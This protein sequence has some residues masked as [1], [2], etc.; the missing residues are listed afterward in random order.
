MAHGVAVRRAI[1][2]A[3]AEADKQAERGSYHAI[4]KGSKPWV[5][6]GTTGGRT[7]YTLS[8]HHY[9]TEML[10]WEYHPGHG[11]YN[12]IGTWTGWGSVSDQ[13]GVNA[14]LSELGSRMR[15]SRDQRGGGARINP[16]RVG[17]MAALRVA[18]P[19]TY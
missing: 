9:G 11:E 10:R 8:L 4:K 2:Q 18:T 6:Y 17:A 1:K 12:I 14:A 13:T 5:V 7:T 19:P 16:Y 15:Y 3:H